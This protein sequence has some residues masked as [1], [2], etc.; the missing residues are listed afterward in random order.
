LATF[1]LGLVVL[2]TTRKGVSTEFAGLAIG[3][4][5]TVLPTFINVT[6]RRSILPASGLAVFVGGRRLPNSGYSCWRPPSASCWRV[7]AAA[8]EIEPAADAPWAFPADA[9]GAAR[10]IPCHECSPRIRSIGRRRTRI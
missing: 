6:G 7:F 8:V 4:T 2:A 5:V 1:I 9:R 10:D 3:L